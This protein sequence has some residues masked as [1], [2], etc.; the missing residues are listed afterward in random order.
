[1]PA[2]LLP[3]RAP[4]AELKRMRMH[5]VL[6][7]CGV[8]LRCVVMRGI[9]RVVKDSVRICNVYFICRAHQGPPLSFCCLECCSVLE[10]HA[11]NL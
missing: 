10:R 8:V 2:R 7:C 9:R 3:L 5:V 11:C 6:W 4:S 1:M